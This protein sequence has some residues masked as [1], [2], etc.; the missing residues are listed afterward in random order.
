[1]IGS[2]ID[3]TRSLRRWYAKHRRDLPWR[4]PIGAAPGGK[5][6]PYHVLVSEAM[7]QQTQVATVIPYFQQFIEQFPAIRALA[8]AQPQTVLRAW[9]GLGYYSRARNLQSA[10]R[11]IVSDFGG[12]VPTNVEELLK[13][14]GVGRYTA[15]AISSIAFE[16][17]SPIL[18]GNVARVLCRLD[19][20]RRDPREPAT[21]EKLWERAEQMLPR[22]NIGDFNSALMELGALVCTPR[23]PR[24][25]VCPVRA[26]CQAFADG[27]QGKIPAPRPA[28]KT[29]LIERWTFCIRDGDRYLVQQRPAQGRWAGMWQF[30]TTEALEKPPSSQL[31]RSTFSLRVSEPSVLGLVEHAL[32]HR[33][34][35]FEVFACESVIPAKGEWATLEE[36]NDR[37]MPGPHLKI[38]QMLLREDANRST[39][40]IPN[41]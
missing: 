30:F 17:R 29:P 2:T 7:L 39:N 27:L 15:G 38:R 32:T 1:M 40:C 13:L 6:N 16:Q 24:C 10:A 26:S 28:K 5:P 33:R 20:V 23:A 41:L 31:L 19:A 37:P 34:Y 11:M 35:R 12:H 8:Q 9:Q 22:R 18:D 25:L 3:F 36:L 14:P 4:L 21:R